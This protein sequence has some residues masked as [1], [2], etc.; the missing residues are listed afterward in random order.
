MGLFGNLFK[1]KEKPIVKKKDE[2]LANSSKVSM[3]Q[4]EE[5]QVYL[6]DKMDADEYNS[7]F[8]QACRMIPQGQYKEAIALFESI[9]ENS[10]DAYEKGSC[11]SQIGA[12]HFF[13]GDFEKALEFYAK[14]FHSGYDQGVIDFNIWEACEELMKIDGNKAKWS[15]YY[16][17]LFPSGEYARKAKKNVA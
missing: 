8:N 4:M 10:T 5:I 14:S 7:A 16:L 9:R 3:E 2:L 17:E 1:K 15:Q 13:L 12:C 11:E 6:K